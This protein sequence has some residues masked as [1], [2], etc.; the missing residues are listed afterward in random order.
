MPGR[1]QTVNRVP[2]K[3]A[4]ALYQHHVDFSCIAVCHQAV[5]SISVC[6]TRSGNALVNIDPCVFPFGVILNEGA[7][8]ADLASLLWAMDDTKKSYQKLIAATDELV[9]SQFIGPA[10]HK[11]FC[12]HA[13]LQRRCA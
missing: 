3:S 6:C 1:I 12:V 8:V 10:A 2:G 13:T 11:D 5:E 4:D 9:K 7:V